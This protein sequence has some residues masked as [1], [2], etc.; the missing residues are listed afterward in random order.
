[1]ITI[2][3]FPYFIY[4]SVQRVFFSVVLWRAKNKLNRHMAAAVVA[5]TAAFIHIKS[6]MMNIWCASVCVCAVHLVVQCSFAHRWQH[7]RQPKTN[8]WNDYFLLAALRFGAML[9][10]HMCVYVSMTQTIFLRDGQSRWPMLKLLASKYVENWQEVSRSI[11]ISHWTCRVSA[12]CAAMPYDV[13]RC[14]SL[15]NVHFTKE[16]ASISYIF[17]FIINAII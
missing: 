5:V 1:M 10:K 3:V 14:S 15:F 12:H 2:I 6:V 16:N 7:P 4:I 13:C 17:M 11:V 8:V 9:H